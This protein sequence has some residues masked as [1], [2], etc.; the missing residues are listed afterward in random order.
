MPYLRHLDLQF[1]PMQWDYAVFHSPLVTLTLRPPG[2][3][4]QLGT[5]DQLVTALR[6]LA[7]TL[8]HLSLYEAFPPIP[9][10]SN[11]PASEEIVSF[12]RLQSVCLT[13]ST[14]QCDALL[15]Y[16]DFSNESASGRHSLFIE[17]DS[18][19]GIDQLSQGSSRRYGGSITKM[20]VGADPQRIDSVDITIISSTSLSDEIPPS[21]PLPIIIREAP[22]LFSA[23]N[24]LEIV[25]SY[26]QFDWP[27]LFA[28]VPQLK[29][30]CL[31]VNPECI[32]FL[33]ALSTF[34]RLGSS[35]VVAP[36]PNLATLE[37]AEIPHR[38]PTDEAEYD[39]WV[40]SLVD[41]FDVRGKLGFPLDE[42][43]FRDCRRI[44]VS[45]VERLKLS[46]GQ[47]LVTRTGDRNRR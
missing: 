33:S 35:D 26:P 10:D 14:N 20:R 37:L 22:N 39:V 34:D 43:R 6:R 21:L 41:C 31:C 42:L 8:E 36:L 5:F 17:G 40:C 2:K 16:I 1:L 47:V 44:R 38:D 19:T 24:E 23:L 7:P 46:I 18:S 28:V 27:S 25:E 32:L 3:A 12:S 45:D 13:G 29:K 4:H 9:V 15:R 11:A 30:L